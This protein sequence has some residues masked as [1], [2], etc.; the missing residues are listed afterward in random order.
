MPFKNIKKEII[1]IED[2]DDDEPISDNNQIIINRENTDSVVFS[3]VKQF[4]QRSDFGFKK[5]GTNLDRK[6][7]PPSDWIQHAQE[8]HMDAILYLEKL[9]Q[10]ISDMEF[11]MQYL[12]NRIQIDEQIKIFFVFFV[13]LLFYNLFYHIRL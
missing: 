5:Y 7:L 13:F 12:E 11:K 8:E 4:K 1:E 2:D 10:V 6:D 9:K 3:I